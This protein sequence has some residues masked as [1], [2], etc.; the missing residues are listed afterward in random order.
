MKQI[1]VLLAGLLVAKLATAQLQINP[2]IKPYGSVFAD[3]PGKSVWPDSATHFKVVIEINKSD[4]NSTEVNAGLDLVARFLNL[5]EVDGVGANRRQ[6]VV[7][8]HNAGSYIL[9]TDDAFKSRYGHTNPNTALLSA[10]Q[11]AG[12][13]MMVCGQSTVK[14]QLPPQ[15]LHPAVRIASSY[16]TAHT[17]LQL[18]GYAILSF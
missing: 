10:L 8:F 4:T 12:V 5:L 16:L 1:V 13:N 7:L 11:A 17:W 9:Q 18:K 14:R 6:I 2:V 3:V 15:V